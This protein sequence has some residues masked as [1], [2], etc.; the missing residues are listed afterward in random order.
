[1]IIKMEKTE[2]VDFIIELFN[3][4]GGDLYGGEAVTQLEHGLQAAHFAK[5]NR[6]SA[7]LTTG[8][9]LHDIG[10]LLHDLPD[11]ATDQGI[12]DVH[13]ALG[14]QFLTQYF[15]D[16]VV[17]SVKLHVAAK[18]YLCLVEPSYYNTLS[19]VSKASLLLQGGIMNAQEKEAF[20][21]NLFYK[22]AVDLRR[23]DDMAKDPTLKVDPIESYRV[24][25][26][27]ALK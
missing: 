18:R 7:E 26:Q 5:Q 11:D 20:E 10:H 22:Q 8:A 13:E 3:K 1:M 6:V 12:D 14:A 24:T 4:K 17:E 21:T 25:I 9:L 16:E 19:P 27:N 23:W 2:V 15:K